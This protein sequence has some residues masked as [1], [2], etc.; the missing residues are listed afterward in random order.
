M[1]SVV[2]TWMKNRPFLWF[3]LPG[4][5]LYS[6]FSIYPIFSAIQISLTKW[7]GIGAKTFVGFDNYVELFSNPEL[8]K[9]LT[10]ALLNSGT[11]FY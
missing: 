9:Q 8:S 1:T 6:I 5:I 3:I 7:D 2:L 11:I 10:N 4:F